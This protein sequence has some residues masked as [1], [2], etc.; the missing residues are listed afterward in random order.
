MWPLLLAAAG[1]QD[2]WQ[3][4]AC[5][6]HPMSWRQA[7]TTGEHP[8]VE[9][10][11]HKSEVWTHKGEVRTHRGMI[12]NLLRGTMKSYRYKVRLMPPLILCSLLL[13]LQPCQAWAST[14]VGVGRWWA[15]TYQFAQSTQGHAL[16]LVPRRH[17]HSEFLQQAEIFEYWQ[18]VP[19]K[20][21][22]QNW[23]ALGIFYPDPLQG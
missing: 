6:S 10:R 13:G 19:H 15:P 1:A 4:K 12:V 22:W 5:L 21:P 14:R 18:C 16:R 17:W 8:V 3:F 7:W 9:V 20:S 23:D 11:T 2:S